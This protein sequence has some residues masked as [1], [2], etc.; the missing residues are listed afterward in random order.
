MNLST[1]FVT[2][3]VVKMQIHVRSS[4]CFS[5]EEVLPFLLGYHLSRHCPFVLFKGDSLPCCVWSN[6]WVPWRL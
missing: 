5:R 6:L 4:D 3:T 2:T 1:A